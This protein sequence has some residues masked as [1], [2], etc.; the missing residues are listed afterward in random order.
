MSI[1]YTFEGND[2][3]F[4]KAQETDVS[5]LYKCLKD[6]PD[7]IWESKKRVRD[8]VDLCDEIDDDVFEK[9]PIPAF[10][11]MIL[12]LKRSSD[13]QNLGVVMFN[14]TISHTDPDY[15]GVYVQYVAIHPDFRG[16]GYYTILYNAMA[17]LFSQ[18]MQVDE[19]FYKI[20]PT[21]VQIKHKAGSKGGSV[22]TLV[23]PLKDKDPLEL[24]TVKWS[25]TNVDNA[26]NKQEKS[27]GI[28][29]D[30]TGKEVKTKRGKLN[31]NKP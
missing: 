29:E 2:Y 14:H 30:K 10:N 7:G 18:F 4:E 16:N 15:T 25:L 3:V 22:G 1:K 8:W 27:A 28:V 31:K 12:I 21:A 5:W 9:S 13:S 26:L 6:F 20:M 23:I 24:N 11:N 19:G 17:W